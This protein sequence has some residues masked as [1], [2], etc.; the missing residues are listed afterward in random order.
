MTTSATPVGIM[1]VRENGPSKMPPPTAL[2]RI[3]VARRF[4]C[5]TV[6]E[7]PSFDGASVV[8]VYFHIKFKLMSISASKLPS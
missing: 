2:D 5:P 6:M 1:E 4:A 8:L 3:L 7:A